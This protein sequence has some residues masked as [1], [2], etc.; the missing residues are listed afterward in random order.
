MTPHLLLVNNTD[1]LN[2]NSEFAHKSGLS[3]ARDGGLAMSD[4][5]C[6]ISRRRQQYSVNP[7]ISLALSR[8]CNGGD[9]TSNTDSGTPWSDEKRPTRCTNGMKASA[10]CLV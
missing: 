6:G 5:V 3:W 2:Q 10:Y 4:L 8:N 7:T 9:T 1:L